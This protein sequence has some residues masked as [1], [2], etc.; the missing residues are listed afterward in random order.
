MNELANM[1]Q[2]IQALKNCG[3]INVTTELSCMNNLWEKLAEED[4]YFITGMI[5]GAAVTLTNK[6]DCA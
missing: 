6:K 4:K 1:V 5:K 2:I 3:I